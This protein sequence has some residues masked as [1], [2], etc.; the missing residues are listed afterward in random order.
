M[1]ICDCVRDRV[2][3]EI[4]GVGKMWSMFAFL[5]LIRIVGKILGL[6]LYYGTISIA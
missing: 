1:Y 3:S 6:T 4:P 5:G 2:P